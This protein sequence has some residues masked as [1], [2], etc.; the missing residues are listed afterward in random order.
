MITLIRNALKV[1]FLDAFWWETA[2]VGGGPITPERLKAHIRALDRS[3]GRC[4]ML[5]LTNRYTD[6]GNQRGRLTKMLKRI[7]LRSA[8][9]K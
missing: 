7:E 2:T 5:G 4:M 3:L 1:G 8:V 9:A 6:L